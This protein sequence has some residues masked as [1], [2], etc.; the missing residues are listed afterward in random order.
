MSAVCEIIVAMSVEQPGL[1]WN[2]R[3]MEGKDCRPRFETTTKN[4]IS[5]VSMITAMIIARKSARN[6]FFWKSLLRPT[7]KT[8]FEPSPI[9]KRGKKC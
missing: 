9:G 3:A 8:A 5:D 1:R 7:V 4:T 6:H 2:E